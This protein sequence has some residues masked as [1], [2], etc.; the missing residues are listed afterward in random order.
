[1][2]AGG[3]LHGPERLGQPLA[4]HAFFFGGGQCRRIGLGGALRRL[5]RAGNQGRIALLAKHHEDDQH[6]EPHDDGHGGQQDPHDERFSAEQ[7]RREQPDERREEQR[8]DEAAQS[9]DRDQ[10][11]EYRLHLSGP[12]GTG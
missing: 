9:P 11:R 2:A 8:A 12:H 7:R 5:G 3:R 6:D 10:R 4:D 1:M